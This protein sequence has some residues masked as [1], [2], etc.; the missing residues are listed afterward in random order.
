M[1]I[2]LDKVISLNVP[3]ELIIGRIT[4]RR[5]CSKCSSSFHFEFNFSKEEDI[6][7]YCDGELILEKDDNAEL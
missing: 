5:V 3:D 2:S 7:D 1:D 6:C 4:G